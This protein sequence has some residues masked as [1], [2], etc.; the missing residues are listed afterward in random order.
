VLQEVDVLYMSYGVPLRL[1]VAILD[2]S[3]GISTILRQ[4]QGSWP[5]NVGISQGITYY[6]QTWPKHYAVDLPDSHNMT[7]MHLAPPRP[8]HNLYVSSKWA[9]EEGRPEPGIAL[10]ASSTTLGIK[11]LVDAPP[12][13]K[14]RPELIRR[15]CQHLSSLNSSETP[16]A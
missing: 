2:V 7:G 13:C 9:K 11:K 4:L 1:Q 12:G 10:A 6:E 14:R 3:K 5:S 16:H 8:R 15:S